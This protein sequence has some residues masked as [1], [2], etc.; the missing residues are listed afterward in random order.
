MDH[1]PSINFNLSL[2]ASWPWTMFMSLVGRVHV[3]FPIICM[4]CS[5]FLHM[6]VNKFKKLQILVKMCPEIFHSKEIS[7]R[8]YHSMQVLDDY[9]RLESVNLSLPSLRLICSFVSGSEVLLIDTFVQLEY[10]CCYQKCTAISHRSTIYVHYFLILATECFENQNT[11][12][13][14]CNSNM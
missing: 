12:F 11:V 3:V 8:K 4:L 7:W 10:Y 2:M 14:S 6:A 13:M 5:K 1:P 9:H